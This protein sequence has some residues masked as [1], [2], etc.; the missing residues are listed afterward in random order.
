MRRNG[1]SWV[2]A[3]C[4]TYSARDRMLL[5]DD[6]LDVFGGWRSPHH[7]EDCKS[8]EFRG[9]YL[10]SRHF[11][12]PDLIAPLP[13]CIINDDISVRASPSMHAPRAC[14]M[15][16]PPAGPCLG[17]RM[18]LGSP[19]TSSA[20]PWMQ[21]ELLQWR[22]AR[23]AAPVDEVLDRPRPDMKAG[24]S[25]DARTCLWGYLSLGIFV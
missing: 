3:C 7:S 22:L 10:K 17:A 16:S 14:G 8:I 4:C 19:R 2:A 9:L 25:R 6:V 15:P 20:G 5:S 12:S 18:T 11:F 23:R 13:S 1:G 21:V 24:G